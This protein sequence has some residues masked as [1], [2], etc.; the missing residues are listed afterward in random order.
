MAV[1]PACP[2]DSPYR[3][4]AKAEADLNAEIIVFPSYFL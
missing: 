2:S 1:C 4:S 3:S